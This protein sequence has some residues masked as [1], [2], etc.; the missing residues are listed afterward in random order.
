MKGQVSKLCDINGIEIP[1]SMLD[2]EIPDAQVI[3]KINKLALRHAKI[4]YPDTV[5]AGDT[6]YCTADKAAYPDGRT[7]VILTSGLL[8]GTAAASEALLLKK[9][10][11][12]VKT[13]L[14]EKNVELTVNKIL[15]RTPVKVDDELII[16]L[17][18]DG[19][20]TVKEYSEHVKAELLEDLKSERKKEITR[21]VLENLVNNSSYIYD[22]GELH[23]Y[24]EKYV[25]DYLKEFPEESADREEIEEFALYQ[26]KQAWVAKAIA[27]LHKKV[28]DVK[29]AEEYTDRMI[30][31]MALTGEPIPN[32]EEILE[33]TLQSE[34]QRLLF[35]VIDEYITNRTEE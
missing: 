12:T 32:R 14:R 33:M 4:S 28:P 10:G 25:A 5:C 26:A 29:Q 24:T 35:E 23:D 6:V 17:N 8:E 22:E 7:L 20:K 18:I 11:D 1:Q 31:M 27:D 19:V 2:C 13:V 9:P 30:E 34:Y 3:E 16:S 15:R 21:F